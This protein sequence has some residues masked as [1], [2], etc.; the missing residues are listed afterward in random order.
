MDEPAEYSE[1]QIVAAAETA[2]AVYEKHQNDPD[3]WRIVAI[4]TLATADFARRAGDRYC[5]VFT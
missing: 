2:C 3:L 4:Q 1:R 5:F